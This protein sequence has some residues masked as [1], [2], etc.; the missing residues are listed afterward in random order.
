[1]QRPGAGAVYLN[2]FHYDVLDFLDSKKINADEQLRLASISIGLVVPDLFIKLAQENKELYM[3]GPHSIYQ[4]YGL[5]LNDINIED[6][7]E[8]FINNPNIYKRSIPA[9]EMLNIIS[10]SQLQ[11]GYPYLMFKD[12][13]N[14]VHALKEIGNIQISNLCT[15]IFQLQETSIIKDYGE[16]DKIKRDISCNLG[17]LNITNVME[18]KKIKQSIYEGIEALTFVSDNT[19]ISTAPGVSK[20]NRELH[21]VGLGAMGLHS[22]LAKN[23]V[24]Y[25]SEEGKDFANTFFM[26]MN[27]Y[28]L[29]KSMYIARDRGI[30]FKDFEKSEYAKGTYFD[31]YIENDYSPKTEKVQSLFEGI[32]IPTKENWMRLKNYV[33]EHG[34]YHAYRLAIAPTQSISY[35]QNA[36]ASVSPVVD[37]IERRLYGNSETYYPMPFLDPQTQWF[38]TTAYNMDQYKMLD[39]MA[40][41]QEHIDQGVSTILYVNS[42]I[43]TRELSRL[44]LYA[45]HKGLKSLY[46]TRNRLLTVD[47]CIACSV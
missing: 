12:N 47:E 14:K 42:N 44:Y 21:S 18:S 16:E 10:S 27:Y 8:E 40:V 37:L 29:K 38:Y 45:H 9:R 5:K 15:E 25:E 39:M 30:V 13:A 19:D 32:K 43:S 4:E 46:Y 1:M 31:K 24:F 26:M 35:I 22:Y 28:S 34:L 36:S 33:M 23:H 20:A 41:I 11:S 2:I 6:Y 17:S 7:Y 3:F